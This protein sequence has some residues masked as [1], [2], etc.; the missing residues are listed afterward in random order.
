MITYA[1]LEISLMKFVFRFTE[2]AG[3]GVTFAGLV[4]L[5]AWAWGK[6][7]DKLSESLGL[8]RMM[9][10]MIDASYK[11]RKAIKR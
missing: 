5:S 1:E 10:K 2:I 11:D 3:I 4:F 8:T 9:I 7:V 6:A